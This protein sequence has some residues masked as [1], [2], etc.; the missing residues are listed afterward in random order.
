MK[1]HEEPI[2]SAVDR[3]H[4]IA[5]L[6]D[7]AKTDPT[8]RRHLADAAFIHGLIH[9]DKL[10]LTLVYVIARIKEVSSEA[11]RELD[12][13]IQKETRRRAKEARR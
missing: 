8:A 10:D 4:Q 5:S 7:D 1:P 3:I 2:I 6:A 13:V 9:S 11:L 12:H